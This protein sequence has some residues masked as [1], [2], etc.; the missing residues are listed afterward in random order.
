M[1]TVLCT[2]HY[3]R[4]SRPVVVF[5]IV[6]SSVFGSLVFTPEGDWKV[7]PVKGENSIMDRTVDVVCWRVFDEKFISECVQSGA[8]GIQFDYD[9][10]F[11]VFPEVSL[12]IAAKGLVL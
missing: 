8:N 12:A 10:R 9:D 5:K 11:V 2:H 7:D 1:S 3:R 6:V 4:G